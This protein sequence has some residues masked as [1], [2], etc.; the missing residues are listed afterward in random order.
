MT[1]IYFL[2]NSVYKLS[3]DDKQEGWNYA[4][5]FFGYSM[6]YSLCQEVKETAEQFHY[7]LYH[8]CITL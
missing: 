3:E 5:N 8:K 2:E 7:H 6:A 1:C 4:Q